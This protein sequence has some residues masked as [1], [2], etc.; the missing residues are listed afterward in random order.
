MF[1]TIKQNIKSIDIA[2]E[3]FF[4]LDHKANKSKKI[5]FLDKQY[6]LEKRIFVKI[7]RNKAMNFYLQNE[8]KTID[9]LKRHFNCKR[10]SV[11][12][13]E[14]LYETVHY[15]KQINCYK[16]IVSPNCLPLL[17]KL[18]N[19]KI[20][21]NIMESKNKLDK[22]LF[23][24]GE[25]HGKSIP[26]EY[27]NNARSFFNLNYA[28]YFDEKAFLK[29]ERFFELLKIGFLH[30][31]F[32]PTNIKYDIKNNKIILFDFEHSSFS[33]PSII[34]YYWLITHIFV[35]INNRDLI[36]NAIKVYDKLKNDYVINQKELINTEI[37]ATYLFIFFALKREGS[38]MSQELKKILLGC[39]KQNKAIV[40]FI[41]IKCR[42]KYSS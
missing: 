18:A 21:I 4:T 40:D 39:L 37:A 23:R 33:S 24:K 2:Y 12:L 6:G 25:E 19:K 16:Y 42:Q 34:D 5:I 38:F 13:P 28:D 8:V 36:E 35:E 27:L 7:S 10:I 1:E 30:N 22:S 15:G 14:L 17:K 32:I 41:S 9:I 11:E 31:D 29:K 26:V 3:K 20:L